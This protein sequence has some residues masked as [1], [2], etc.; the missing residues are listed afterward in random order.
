MVVEKELK[1]VEKVPLNFIRA[2]E[3]NFGAKEIGNK[4]QAYGEDCGTLSMQR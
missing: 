1:T 2:D 4:T 3:L